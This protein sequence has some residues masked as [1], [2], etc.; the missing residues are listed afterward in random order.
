MEN[1]R[2]SMLRR[3]FMILVLILIGFF[4]LSGQLKP[5][6]KIAGPGV[7]YVLLNDIITVF[8]GYNPDN[9]EEWDKIINKTTNKL[10]SDAKNAKSL[11]QI[12]QEFYERYKRILYVIKLTVLKKAHPGDRVLDSLILEQVSSFKNGEGHSKIGTVSGIGSIAAVLAEELIYLKE[13]LDKKG[14]KKNPLILTDHVTMKV[15]EKPLAKY[16][17]EIKDHPET[18]EVFLEVTVDRRGNVMEAVVLQGDTR[19]HQAAL[20][21]IK[22][23]KYK[24]FILNGKPRYVKFKE[25]IIF[26]AKNQ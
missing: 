23:Y 22:K 4:I 10:L 7:G 17:E 9:P 19:F 1:R 13:L 2:V 18:V 16:P 8:E 25:S 5:L 26:K 6:I 21:T 24:P 3:I 14:N 11:D 15:L 12:D 20:L